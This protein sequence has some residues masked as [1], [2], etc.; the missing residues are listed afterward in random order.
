MRMGWRFRNQH[1]L[2]GKWMWRCPVSDAEVTRIARE[3]L[4]LRVQTEDFFLSFERYP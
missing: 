3:G 2:P 1:A 4:V